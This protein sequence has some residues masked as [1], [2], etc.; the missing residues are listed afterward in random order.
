MKASLNGTIN[1]VGK[2]KKDADT[3]LLKRGKEIEYLKR[4]L[5]DCSGQLSEEKIK[6][7]SLV[8]EIGK[9][10]E[11]LTKKMED[12]LSEDK[13]SLPFTAIYQV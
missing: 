7:S 9:N 5:D 4:E 2:H 8:Q 1:E 10:R 13:A 6:N 12:L 11:Q 3:E